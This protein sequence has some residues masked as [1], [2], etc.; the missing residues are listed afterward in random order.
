MKI[1]H[2]IPLN[3]NNPGGVEKHVLRLS[4]ALRARNINVD[5]FGK[6]PLTPGN[7]HKTPTGNLAGFRPLNEFDLRRYDIIHTH[8]GFLTPRLLGMLLHR[9]ARQ[10]WIH[11]LHGLATDY[12]LKCRAWR[13]WRCYWCSFTEAMWSHYADHTITVS[14][15][16]K[17]QAGSYYRLPATKMTVIYNGFEADQADCDRT[18]NLRRQYDLDESHFVILFIGRGYDR[19]KGTEL[20]ATTTEKLWR[21][22]PQVRL[23]TIPGDGFVDAP[24]L[25]RTGPMPHDEIASHCRISDIMVNASL[26][27][28]FPL[29]IVEAMGNR[30]PVVAAPVGGIPEIIRHE[31]SGLLL[32][33]DRSDLFQQ[34]ERLITNPSL[35]KTLTDN[36]LQISR[37]LTWDHLARQTCHVYE[38]IRTQKLEA[39][40]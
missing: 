24:W 5:V 9:S 2:Y 21:K 36:A 35:R 31:H 22:Y 18:H 29:T 32:R 15:L 12:L 40:S 17:R 3:L 14:R 39:V 16:M 38:G 20:I 25:V 34:L 1:A 6:A 27:E 37:L 28:G 26:S 7:G 8:S 11:T 30:L 10:R 33:P 4:E 19:V 13:N 23:L